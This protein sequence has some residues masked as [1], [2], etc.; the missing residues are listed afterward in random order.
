MIC[1]SRGS[2]SRLAKAAGAEPSGSNERWKV[3]RCCGAKHILKLKK[4]KTHLTFEALLEVDISKKCTPLWREYTFPSQK[5]YKALTIVPDHFRKLRCWRTWTPL[6]REANFPS[7]KCDKTRPVLGPLL[8]VQMS[9]NWTPWQARMHIVHVVKSEQNVK[10]RTTCR[11]RCRLTWPTRPIVHYIRLYDK[12][13][14]TWHSTA[15]TFQLQ[16]QLQ[17]QVL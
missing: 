15:A 14:Y 2:K 3:A 5:C 8:D 17:L 12:L 10:V 4:V 16:L 7:Q 11:F 6:W 1:G 13:D 9:K